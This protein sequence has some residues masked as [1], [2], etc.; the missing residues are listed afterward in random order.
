MTI[1]KTEDIF[2]DIPDD[3]DNV[4]MKIPDEICKI[5]DLTEGDK[6]TIKMEKDGLIIQKQ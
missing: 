5:L 4:L 3:P 1:Y 2:T 6:V